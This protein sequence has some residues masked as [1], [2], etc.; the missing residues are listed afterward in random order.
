M[1]FVED[2]K[3]A[4]GLLMAAGCDV[5]TEFM[6][7]P[8]YSGVRCGTPTP[9]GDYDGETVK[10]IARMTGGDPW[11]SVIAKGDSM[12]GARIHDGDRLYV[13]VQRTAQS[14]D[15]VVAMLDGE[16]V[17]K[18]FFED[19][20]G[21]KW[22]VPANPS[23]APID[24]ADY[25]DCRLMGVVQMVTE[26]ERPR[27]S[28]SECMKA[29]RLAQGERKT[30]GEVSYMSLCRALKVVQDR[31]T[32]NRQWYSVYRVLVDC[33]MIEC[34][35]YDAFVRLLGDVMKESAP[36]L[37]IHDIRKMS[38]GSFSKPVSQWNADNAPV[39][40]ARFYSYLEIANV[41]KS[42]LRK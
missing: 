31:I 17:V 34:E 7:I 5:E 30:V 2:L 3:E 25:G 8:L 38:V 1:R 37:N 13:R 11:F 22:L 28:I 21:H 19:E 16:A 18:V 6:D 10:L 32:A 12:V 42:E 40:S 36:V 33:S 9:V 26:C 15:I 24:P 27:G 35:D 23:Y 20:L 4:V 41:F 14:G 29:V 39:G